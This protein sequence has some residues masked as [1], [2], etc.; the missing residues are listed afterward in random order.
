[1]GKSSTDASAA[2]RLAL[3]LL[4]RLF[5][6]IILWRNELGSMIFVGVCFKVIAWALCKNE[7][8]SLQV[9]IEEKHR[10]TC[11]DLTTAR[12]KSWFFEKISTYKLLKRGVFLISGLGFKTNT[13]KKVWSRFETSSEISTC[14][15]INLLSGELCALQAFRI[16]LWMIY[17]PFSRSNARWIYMWV[18][19]E[20][21]LEK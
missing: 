14:P 12:F 16:K 18:E 4:K 21:F 17:E 1:M 6:K 20:W 19:Q 15:V 2:E 3:Q 9:K 8:S 10:Q 7:S 5:W 13:G 11:Q